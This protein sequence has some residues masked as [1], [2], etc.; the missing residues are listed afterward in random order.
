MACDPEVR[1]SE[2]SEQR[3][4]FKDYSRSSSFTQKTRGS[5]IEGPPPQTPSARSLTPK[6]DRCGELQG[7]ERLVMNKKEWDVIIFAV[8]L[9]LCSVISFH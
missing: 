1:G 9:K 6:I 2:L 7:A 4:A 8:L 3:P 5:L